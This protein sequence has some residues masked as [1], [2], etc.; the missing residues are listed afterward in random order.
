MPKIRK[1][2]KDRD[3]VITSGKDGKTPSDEDRKNVARD[4]KELDKLT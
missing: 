2:K 4:M 3:T 1:M